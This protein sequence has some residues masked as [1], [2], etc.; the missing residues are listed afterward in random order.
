MMVKKLTRVLSSVDPLAGTA[1]KEILRKITSAKH[2]Q[3][4]GTKMMTR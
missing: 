2:V 4:V 3:Q 1:S